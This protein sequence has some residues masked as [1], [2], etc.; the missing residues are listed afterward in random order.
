M[1]ANLQKAKNS[2]IKNGYTCVLF[3]GTKE[4]SSTLRGVKP[5]ID[6]LESDI[7]F[8][9]FVAADKTVGAGAAYLYVLLGVGA[10]YARIISEPAVAVLQAHGIRVE[11]DRI[12]PNIINRRGD[13]ICPFEAA[14]MEIP[15]PNEAYRA[16]LRK[17]QEMNI[18]I[19]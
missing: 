7:N 4:Y 5:L 9:G 16:I 10:V 1:N 13:G 6:F 2:L 18:P 11:C 14:V 19:Q 8:K 3:N 15:E 12:V 17:M